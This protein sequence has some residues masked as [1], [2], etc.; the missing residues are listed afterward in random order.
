MPSFVASITS[1]ASSTV[2]T[3]LS[4]VINTYWLTILGV[5]FVGAMIA[6]FWRFAHR[7]TGR[8]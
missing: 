6:L 7:V 2:I 1:A 4:E 3:F 8:R 5:I